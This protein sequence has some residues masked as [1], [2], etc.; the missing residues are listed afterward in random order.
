MRPFAEGALGRLA[1]TAT[2][3]EQAEATERSVLPNRSM[4]RDCDCERIHG[5]QHSGE[6]TDLGM[7]RRNGRFG[8][9]TLHRCPACGAP[10]LHY[11]VE[12]EAFSRS[13]RWF[14]GRLDEASAASVSAPTAIAT[15]AALAWYWA[16]G[17]YFEGEVSKG[18]GPVPVDLYG[19]R[20]EE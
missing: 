7:D 8:E 20:A 9:V 4:K 19:P 2:E 15:L 17:S 13:G 10:W 18:A 5:L 12:Y 11:Q 6:Q 3:T 16:G 14:C 1:E